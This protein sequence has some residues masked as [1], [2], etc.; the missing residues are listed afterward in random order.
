M[1]RPLEQADDPD[2]AKPAR[3]PTRRYEQRQRAI[4]ASAVE[5]LNR[6][7]IRGMTLGGVAARLNLV[8]TGVIYYF[9]NKEELAEQAFLA[10]IDRFE[11]IIAAAAGRGEPRERVQA[12]IDGFLDFKRQA[13]LG[14][15]EQ[16]AVFNDVRALNS[17]PVNRAYVAMFRSA[18]RLLDPAGGAR[19]GRMHRNARAHLLLS[20]AFWAVAWLPGIMPSD[21]ARVAGRLGA[22]LS[23]GLAAPGARWPTPRQIDLTSGDAAKSASSE[24]F[25]RAATKLINA[26]GYHGA[27]V[28]RISAELKVSKGSF[29]HHNET[30]D[31]LVVACFQRTFDLMW[32]AIWAAEAQ[33][34]TGLET[35][36]AVCSTLI[37]HQFGGGAPLLRTSALTTVPE[38]L[39]HSLMADLDRLSLRFASILCDGVAD[40][41]IRPVDVNVAAQMITGMVNAAAELHYWAPELTIETAT[42]HYVRPLFQGIVAAPAD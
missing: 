20:E 16:I 10:A 36:V 26:E 4:L 24:M 41:S 14:E 29:Y 39:H 38:S 11:A 13:A 28:D 5:E 35:L 31:D 7:G 22:I 12:F 33:G 23:D 1:R 3:A 6:N 30:K 42:D 37:R 8:S 18:R 40:G 27:S 17:A 15:A 32:R 34:G 19:A 2:A 25:L 21:Y 9:K